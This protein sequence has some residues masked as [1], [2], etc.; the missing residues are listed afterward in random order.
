[1]GGPAA[2]EYL[3]LDVVLAMSTTRTL[4]MVRYRGWTSVEDLIDCGTVLTE[5]HELDATYQQ[6]ARMARK[7]LLSRRRLTGCRFEYQI[8]PRGIAKL[9]AAYERYEAG[10]DVL[11]DEE[12]A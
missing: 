3:P 12:A 7:G 8:T 1:M 10:L 11:S 9:R 6:L 4:R 5:Y 2:V